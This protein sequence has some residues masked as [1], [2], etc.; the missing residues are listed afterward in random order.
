[1][2]LMH[3]PPP[4]AAY[5]APQ[6]NVNGAELQAVGKF[7]DLSNTHTRSAPI[8][9]EHQTVDAQCSHLGDAA[10]LRRV[11]DGYKKQARRLNH[12]HLTCLR[13]ILKLGWQD[14]IPYTYALERTLSLRIYAMLRQ[15][16]LKWSD[17]LVWMDE[18]RLPKGLFHGDVVMGSVGKVVR[19]EGQDYICPHCDRT[20]T[21]RIGLVSHLRIHRTETGEPVPGAPTYTH[22]T[23]LNCQ[24]CPRTFNHRMGLFGHM[25][26]HE[27]GIDH[28][29]DTP[30]TPVM[31][32]TTL[33]PSVCTTTNAS[34]VAVIS[35]T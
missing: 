10:A 20:F 22:R 15:T 5:D 11:V 21:S 17:Q 29:S 8:V 30:T 9:N 26:I 1:M 19:C 28:N 7:T 16:Q 2:V 33:A 12:V 13:R 23:R 27:S 18:E 31:P 34:S 35:P 3:S 24:H 14:Q 6:I 25:R 32:S 4:N